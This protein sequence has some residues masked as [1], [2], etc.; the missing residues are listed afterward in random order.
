MP[1]LIIDERQIKVP[2]RTKVIE[3]AEQLGIMIPRFCYH[4]A[5]G[6]VGA[7]RVC[8]VKCLEGPV[9]GVQMSCMLDAQEGMVISTTDPEAVDFRRHIIEWLMVNHPHD[10]PVCDEGG[11]CLL[12]DLTVAGGH[13]IRR[14]E[15]PKRT[16]RDQDLG[17]LIQHEM[18]RCIHCFRCARYY[19]EY[20]GY[21][22][23]G[24]MG[25][26]ARTYFGR[27]KD[28]PLESPYCGNLIDI[29]PTGVYTDK[30][31]RFLGR[32]WDFERHPSICI[33]CGL[34]CHLTVSARYRQVVRQE[35][36]HN[37]EGNGH[38]IC[39]RGRYGF[40]YVNHQDRP[41]RARV[42]EQ[43]VPLPDALEQTARKLRDLQTAHGPQAIA[44]IGSVRSSL[45]ALS[46]L[47]H[48]C[49]QMQ[50]FG[51][52]FGSDDHASQNARR[53]VGRLLPEFS[54]TLA[55]VAKSDCILALGV[56]PV[57][58]APMLALA[59]RQAARNGATVTVSDPRP[60]TL[61]FDFQRLALPPA[62]LTQLAGFLISR[63]IPRDAIESA[64]EQALSYYAQLPLSIPIET[65][66][67]A[68]I[69]RALR[70]S[71]RPVI[72]CGTGIVPS[73]L[74]DIAADMVQLQ[75]RA[76]Q[77]SG[78]FY[79]MS[80]ANAFGAAMLNDPNDTWETLLTQ[81]E[82]R[83]I[84]GLVVVEDDPF[85]HVASRQRLK[86]AFAQLDLLI[87]LDYIASE[88]SQ[89]ADVVL[90][91]RTVY[92]TE[93]TF[94]NHSGRAQKTVPVY[95][96]GLPIEQISGGEH[97]PRVF[98]DQIPMTEAMAA[99][100]TLEALSALLADDDNASQ[101]GLSTPRGT[102]A[103]ARHF[104]Q[105]VEIPADGVAL[106]STANRTLRPAFETVW[107]DLPQPPEGFELLVVEATFGTE[108]LSSR[109][110]PL[111]DL[112]QKPHLWMHPEDGFALRLLDRERVTVQTEHGTLEATLR[113]SA[114]QSPGVVV[115]PRQQGIDWQSLGATRIVLTPGSIAKA[116]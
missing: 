58:E 65:E 47:K 91:T 40:D 83:H 5:L 37:P 64:G 51:P 106:V 8:A 25:I 20:T 2:P 38:F 68:P 115:I 61:P 21:K 116:D 36:R 60:V 10:C 7:C 17:P 81:I 98:S 57:N 16:F 18:N 53:A 63:T 99:S 27:F 113:L 107:E 22:D 88:T 9:S 6:A 108:T 24:A 26:G 74:P 62:T 49:Q 4:P 33:H 19:Q 111:T 96:G 109:S 31:S 15:G 110:R 101:T 41:R 1:Q 77:Q 94:I 90:P 48:L 32:R 14:Y 87:V 76:G 69:I 35:A 95:R 45:E 39:D 50:W 67:H 82:A 114:D 80:G 30:P 104:P 13:G 55:D 66:I 11:H 79:I 43:I 78:L 102:S 42:G 105:L 75:Q 103:L 86:E 92:E 73:S 72:V 54:A 70:N 59:M 29:C 112:P 93:G 44:G 23:L 56:D 84:R 46:G 89:R 12:Q 100:E 52:V 97:P 28:G 34:G 71:R 85:W 3:A